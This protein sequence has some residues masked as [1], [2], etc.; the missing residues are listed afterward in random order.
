MRIY[1]YIINAHDTKNKIVDIIDTEVR[2]ML[3]GYMTVKEAVPKM[4][5][6]EGRIRQLCINGGIPGAQKVGNTWV[7]PRASVESYKPGPQGFAAVWAR[8]KA[9]GQSEEAGVKDDKWEEWN[10]AREAYIKRF[11][12]PFPPM[13]AFPDMTLAEAAA[14]M[15]RCI[16]EGEPYHFKIS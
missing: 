15:R 11:G 6:T 9:K 1:A 8:R 7:I 13:A 10:N 14:V 4:G 5:L 3:D 16:K 2:I 12:Y